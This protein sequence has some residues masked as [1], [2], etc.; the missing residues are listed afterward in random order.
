LACKCAA[1]DTPIATPSGDRAI[2]ELAVG[3]LVYSVDGDEIRAVP[4]VRI[5]RTPVVNH[6]VLHVV[7]DNGRSIDMSAG[8]PLPD[9]SPLSTLAPGTELIGAAVVSVTS[10]P[11][12][13]PFTYD[14]LPASSSGA[15]FA[16]NV[17]IGST[18]ARSS[19]LTPR[20]TA[21]R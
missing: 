7:F 18:L 14:I 4:I 6:G 17:L 9:G 12:A 13:H 10:V 2:A 16:S 20:V 15:Y 21:S 3:D 8:H 19:A 11:Y 5:N 1:P